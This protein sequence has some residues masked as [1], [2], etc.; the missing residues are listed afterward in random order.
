MW[1]TA[2]SRAITRSTWRCRIGDGAPVGTGSGPAVSRRS[3]V[4]EVPV[5]RALSVTGAIALAAGSLA[6]FVAASP[7]YGATCSSAVPSDFNGDQIA[8]A[9][10]YDGF[11]GGIHVIYGTRSGLTLTHSGTAPANAFIPV[12]TEVD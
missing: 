11:E 6:V 12:S 3:P 10:V 7:A 8:D 9:A 5:R 2:P 1:A 4:E